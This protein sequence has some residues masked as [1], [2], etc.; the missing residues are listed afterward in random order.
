M[1]LNT[2]TVTHPQ[3]VLLEKAAQVLKQENDN[4]SL[5]LALSCCLISL[6]Y[7]SENLKLYYP[8][9]KSPL[10]D[11]VL[12]LTASNT[13]QAAAIAEILM[14]FLRQNKIIHK[15]VGLELSQWILVDIQNVLVHIF[16]PETRDLYQID[17]L[18][19]TVPKITI[20][21]EYYSQ[22]NRLVEIPSSNNNFQDYL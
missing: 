22:V 20:P 21:Q 1:N 18:Y 2:S 5:N 12:V 9:N 10:A 6:Q 19:L 3:N 8:Q 16:L 14:Q 15:V 11:Y 7:K 4:R 17:N 13:T